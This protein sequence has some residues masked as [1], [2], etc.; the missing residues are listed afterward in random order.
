MKK[1]FS[2][3][4]SG[5]Y[6]ADM[7]Y[8]NDLILLDLLQRLLLYFCVGLLNCIT[9]PSVLSQIQIMTE[10]PKI[11]VGLMCLLSSQEAKALKEAGV[12]II[13]G[14]GHS[15][16]LVLR[17]IC[18]VITPP[19][20]HHKFSKMW[21]FWWILCVKF[22]GII[23]EWFCQTEEM[24]A[25]RSLQHHQRCSFCNSYNWRFQCW[26]PELEKRQKN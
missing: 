10:S 8:S 7:F 19:P 20:I 25:T 14:L 9:V 26:S 11:C 24:F 2:R 15:G 17:A 4:Q 3:R 21:L 18:Q 13:I 12:D 5:F 23:T 6:P 1:H 22:G 16:M